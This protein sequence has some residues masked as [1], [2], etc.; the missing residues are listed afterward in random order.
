[1]IDTAADGGAIPPAERRLPPVAELAVVVLGLVVIGGIYLAAH[2]PRHAP[3]ALPIGLLVAACALLFGNAVAL[4]RV[5]DFA[6]D[7]FFQVGGWALLAYVVIA[8]M[9]EYVF[10]L[11]QTRGAQLVVLTLML[12]VFAVDVPMLFAFS[13][14]RY[15][16]AGSMARATLTAPA[17]SRWH[18]APSSD[19]L[20][21]GSRC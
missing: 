17:G 20:R 14:A 2:L 8:G 10:V 3:R 13:V 5:R 6:G 1:V 7:R 18:Y 9:L 11:D 12:I 15:Q 19:R 16:P 4:S 21:C